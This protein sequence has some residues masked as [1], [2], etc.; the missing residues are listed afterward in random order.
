MSAFELLEV[1]GNYF[2]DVAGQ[3]AVDEV[4]WEAQQLELS[5][6][7]QEIQICNTL[8]SVV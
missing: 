3:E 5:Q 7:R 4:R 6:S 8:A 1:F 2:W